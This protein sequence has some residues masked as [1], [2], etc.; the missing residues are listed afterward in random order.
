MYNY[1]WYHVINPF[2]LDLGYAKHLIDVFLNGD[3]DRVINRDSTSSTKGNT[4]DG[5]GDD[6]N[7][8]NC[9]NEHYKGLC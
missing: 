2:L 5:D 7:I 6:I 8:I 3:E 9:S 4:S 1:H